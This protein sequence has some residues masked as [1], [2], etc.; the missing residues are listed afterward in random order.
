MKQENLLTETEEQTVHSRLIEAAKIEFRLHGYE[1]A[2]LRKICARAGVTTGALYFA[3]RN[4]E[5]LFEQ[6][7]RGMMIQLADLSQKMIKEELADASLGVNHEKQL[8][9]LLWKNQDVFIILL[10]NAKGTKYENFKD[11]LAARLE[12]AYDLF[13]QKYGIFQSDKE[14]IRILVKMKIQGYTELIMGGY[15]LDRTLELAQGVGW[16]TDGGFE[17]L[18]QQ[19]NN[20]M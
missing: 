7:V 17:S 5:D 3:F 4:K 8:L 2:S 10:E 12:E 14:L 18:M 15:T 11:E 20:R 6:V 19:L 13:F 1:K 16:Y 9:E